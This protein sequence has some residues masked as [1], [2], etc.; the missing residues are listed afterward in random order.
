[1]ERGDFACNTDSHLTTAPVSH[2][3]HFGQSHLDPS[4]IVDTP[5]PLHKLC[6]FVATSV[7]W[8][9]LIGLARKTI[10]MDKSKPDPHRSGVV[11]IP[12]IALACTG[13]IHFV[14][15]L[16]GIHP[17]MLPV[18]TL[19]AA[20]F[21]AFNILLPVVLFAPLD[22][23]SESGHRYN[24]TILGEILSKV[25]AVGIYLFGTAQITNNASKDHATYCPDEKEQSTRKFIQWTT[26]GTVIGIAACSILRVLDHGM[27]IQRYPMPIIV[28][29]VAGNCGGVFVAIGIAGVRQMVS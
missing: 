19:V 5:L 15:I 22:S 25:K 29:F 28:G 17:T 20:F 12:V 10:L 4:V 26:L 11:Q 16:C 23:I 8:S 21:V 13:I 18:H 1:M 6:T 14:F 7:V 2:H 9:M 3:G 27:Q 24:N